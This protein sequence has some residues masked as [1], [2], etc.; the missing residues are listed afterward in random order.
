MTPADA[1]NI[2]RAVPLYLDRETIEACLSDEELF[3]VVGQVQRSLKS[4]S[5]IVGPKA[6]FGFDIGAYHL[7]AGSVSGGD[8][9]ASAIGIKWFT[10]ADRNPERGLPRVPATVLVCDAETG[11][12]DGVLEA[13]QFTSERTAAMAVSAA[14]AC[15]CGPL[16]R[17]AV[18][19]AGAIGRSLVKFL[20]KTQDLEEIVL[21][22]QRAETARVGRDEVAK[23]VGGGANILAAE[24]IEQAVRGSDVVFTATG[25]SEDTAVVRSE[26]LKDD[27]IVCTLATRREV[28]VQF[29]SEAWIV[30]DD[31][32]GFRLRRS[33]FRE[34]G[35]AWNRIAGDVASLMAG[36]LAPPASPRKI[37]L[38]L[39]G[40]GVLDVALAARA[41]AN[42]RRMGLGIPL[43]KVPAQ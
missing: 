19:G 37:N 15:A 18:I 5:V 12:L 34:G 32:D 21:A 35:A 41:V 10:V 13:T 36:H 40:M 7:H 2:A 33:D 30:V 22:S 8:L 43:G 6:G 3:E 27:V 42:A 9:A 39:I 38:A 26:W 1:P 23:I 28:D 11:M 20:A 4:A 29:L 24:T 16:R 31:A 25:V 17:A 14:A